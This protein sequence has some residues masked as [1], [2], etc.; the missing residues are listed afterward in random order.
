VKTTG[1][2]SV[3]ATISMR[4]DFLVRTA[5]GIVG[6]HLGQLITDGRSATAIFH[7]ATSFGGVDDNPRVIDVT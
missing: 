5:D 7:A 6:Q 3:N 2:D 1:R 4:M